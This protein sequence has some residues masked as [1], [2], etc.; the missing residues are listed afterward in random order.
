MKVLEK[1][2]KT[3]AL[4]AAVV[5]AGAG[6]AFAATGVG[7]EKVPTRDGAKA[8]VVGRVAPGV[9]RSAV[10][11]TETFTYR[12]AVTQTAVV[13]DGVTEASVKVI[14]A[15]GGATWTATNHV[16]GGDGAEIIGNITVAPG[17]VLSIKVGE[18]GGDEGGKGG[19][20]AVGRG[21]PGGSS[22]FGDAYGAGG[23][24]GGASELA[25]DGAPMAIAGGGGGGGGE[26]VEAL[27]Y[28]GG[29]GGSSG[30]TVDAGHNGRGLGAGKGGS[31]AGNKVSAGSGGGNGS[32]G[33]GGGGGGGAGRIG[34]SGGSGGGFGGGGG[35]GGGAG[36]SYRFAHLHNSKVIRGSTPDGNGL[37]QLTWN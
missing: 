16:T 37:I 24:G 30:T 27:T 18:Y 14:G 25:A 15:K 22:I 32:S 10:P 34:G 33:G 13:P 36:S 11:P 29:P 5:V 20:S 26:G 8:K 17:E 12:G 7:S 23:G 6:A 19:W 2:L 31:G 35:G 21:G 28:R 1:A 9:G 3:G 4:G